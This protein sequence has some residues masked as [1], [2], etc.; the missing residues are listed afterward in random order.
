[1]ALRLAFYASPRLAFPGRYRVEYPFAFV[2]ALGPVAIYL[3]LL[4]VINL[5][6]RPH[7]LTGGREI[8]SLAL[9]LVG[10]AIVGPMQLF[11]P[12]SASSTFGSLTWALLLT[13]YSLFTTLWVLLARPRLVIYNLS[14]D[15]LRAVLAKIAERRQTEAHWAGDCLSL[16]KPELALRIEEFRPLRNISL[17]A[18]GPRPAEDAWETFTAELR[19]SLAGLT[20]ARNA[21]GLI[22]VVPAAAIL[23]AV[24]Q[25]T[26]VHPQ[27]I[28]QGFLDLLRL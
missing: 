19:E 18:I 5:S 4:G 21:P 16:E 23:V 28:A 2:V 22:M 17:L 13:L 27:A 26:I 9:A 8:A 15:Q 11:F 25:L 24:V 6:R 3:L 10:F 12:F 20:S 14:A 7:V 1:M